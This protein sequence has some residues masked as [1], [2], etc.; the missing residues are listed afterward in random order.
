MEV[1]WEGL[2]SDSVF[3]VCKGE[4]VA[5]TSSVRIDTVVGYERAE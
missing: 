5:E 4:N 3:E 1:L 2:G